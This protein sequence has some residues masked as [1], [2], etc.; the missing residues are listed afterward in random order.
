MNNSKGVD[1][2]SL[3]NCLTRNMDVTPDGIALT[4]KNKSL[5]WMELYQLVNGLV[6]KYEH[7]VSHQVVLHLSQSIDDV[8]LLFL[9]DALNWQ[10]VLVPSY[11]GREDALEVATSCQA[12]HAIS[13]RSGKETITTLA[14]DVSNRSNTQS[15]SVCLMTS[16]T[17]GKPKLAKHTWQSLGGNIK[18]SDRFRGEKW[19]LGYPIAHFAG[20]QVFLQSVINAGQLIIPSDITPDSGRKL[21][22]E[23]GVNY[24]NAT[25]TYLRQ[26]L[27]GTKLDDWVDTGIKHITLGGEIADQL[28]L[29]LINQYIPQA[30][31]SHIYAS[32]ELG[33]LIRVDD[34]KEGFPKHLL[35]EET[36]KIVDETLFVRRPKNA[37]Q[38]YL[39]S[40]KGVSD[41]VNTRDLVRLEDE[42]VK[43][44]GR[45]DDVINVG[46]FKVNPVVVEN[47]LRQLPFIRDVVITAKKSS[48]AGNLIKVI[49]SLEP[50]FEA[51]DARVEISLFA[52]SKLPYFMVPKLF[53]FVDEVPMTYTNKLKRG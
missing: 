51:R 52:K 20:M 45:C 27:A 11:Y 21:V 2:I 43:F 13:I 40:D 44:V 29:D 34:K 12:Q 33:A 22:L 8:A 32:T 47:K 25:P 50:G 15:P 9:S 35:N 46:G 17:T 30:R 38:C 26:I 36:L 3:I 28:T 19:L 23:A 31:V 16:G 7:M 10:V 5:S 24:L 6:N 39:N 41:W 48:L 37:M 49:A 53:E 18:Q 1:E 4:D 14:S 42:R